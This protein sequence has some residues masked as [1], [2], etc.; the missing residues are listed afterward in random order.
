[1]VAI[2]TPHGEVLELTVSMSRK[3]ARRTAANHFGVKWHQLWAHGYRV[4]ALKD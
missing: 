2:Y 1:M 4:H 3:E